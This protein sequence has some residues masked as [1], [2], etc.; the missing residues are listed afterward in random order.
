MK[1]EKSPQ[2]CEG[3]SRE[4]LK[5]V[6]DSSVQTTITSPPYGF[7]KD[8]GSINQIG[9][10]QSTSDEYF[11]SLRDICI[12]LFRVTKAGGA[13][14]IVA[15]GWRTEK[16]YID[17]P[18]RLA[19]I[20]EDAGWLLQDIVV[21]DKGR[22]LPWSHKGRF[23]NAS[24]MVLLFSKEEL[25]QFNLSSVRE[26]ADLSPYWVRYPERYHPVGKAPSDIWHFPIPVQGSW[27]N[28]TKRHFC[29]FPLQLVKRMIA[30]TSSPGDVVLD[31]FSGTGTVP[32]VANFMARQGIGIEANRDFV[33]SFEESW[34]EE[35]RS[36]WNEFD[37]FDNSNFSKTLVQLKAQKY[38]KALFLELSKKEDIADDFRENVRA[39]FIEFAMSTREKIEEGEAYGCLQVV[40]VLKNKAMARQYRNAAIETSKRPPLSKF[41][42][43][44]SIKVLSIRE[45]AFTSLFTGRKRWHLYELGRFFKVKPAKISV[46]SLPE[47]VGRN[48]KFPPI[49][50]NLRISIPDSLL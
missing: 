42:L 14:W 15:D 50:S 43:D 44:V 13:L 10:G 41:G 17:L 35:M 28:S 29:P 9:Y 12:E 25:S 3:D 20:A 33:S 23:R 37:G 6:Q 49:F 1:G 22:T 21:W 7:L 45:N 34:L 16:R 8:Y 5:S 19:R 2:V 31:P 30:I 47:L 26:L 39:F 18:G 38:P 48:G 40:I 24:E 4:I 36:E 11:E 46:E 27:S 32:A